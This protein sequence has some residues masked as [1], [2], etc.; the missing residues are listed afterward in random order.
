MSAM[1]P[2]TTEELFKTLMMT[3]VMIWCHNIARLRRMK[4][5]PKKVKFIQETSGHQ[6]TIQAQVQELKTKLYD[7]LAS[8]K[9]TKNPKPVETEEGPND[10]EIS[11]AQEEQSHD[12]LEPAD[13]PNDE[14]LPASAE[15]QVASM[16]HPKEDQDDDVLDA[17]SKGEENLQ[18]HANAVQD[19]RK[20]G[21]WTRNKR[22]KKKLRSCPGPRIKLSKIMKL[23]RTKKP[24][25]MMMLPRLSQ[26]RKPQMIMIQN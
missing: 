4:I 21:G 2:P 13:K 7:D 22:V 26:K 25:M 24:S 12:E 6:S 15:L 9:E 20:V 14:K 11:G 1:M 19:L 16:K 23:S 8:L 5:I 3:Q 10:D 18:P 17:H